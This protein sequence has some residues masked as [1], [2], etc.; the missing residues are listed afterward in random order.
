VTWAADPAPASD[1]PDLPDAVVAWRIWRLVDVG[2]TCRL[3]SAFKWAVWQPGAPL[4]ASCLSK[5]TALQR[6]RGRGRHDAPIPGCL[7]GIYGADLGLLES[8]LSAWRDHEVGRVVGQVS[9]WGTVI[10]CEHGYRASFAYPRRLYVPSDGAHWD[11]EKIAGDLSEYRV[12][13]E[14]LLVGCADTM[15]EL[16]RR[17]AA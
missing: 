17:E 2:D 7:C 12:P 11:W 9:L 16:L 4:E 6:L 13:V 1:A 3:V 15:D 10:E 5:P 14:P 8:G